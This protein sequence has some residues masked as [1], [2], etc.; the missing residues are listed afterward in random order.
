[1][2]DLINKYQAAATEYMKRN[3]E[4]AGLTDLNDD[5]FIHACQLAKSVMMTRD[6]V[7]TGGGFVSAVIHNDL[8]SAIGRADATATKALKALVLVKRNCFLL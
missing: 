1:M 2:Q 6:N 4:Y 3:R 8:E 5:E 7:L